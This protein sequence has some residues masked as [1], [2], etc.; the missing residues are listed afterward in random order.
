ME[1]LV[2]Q[3]LRI[4]HII[5]GFTALVVAPL[6]MIAK[7]GGDGHRRWGK[8]FFYAM[9]VVATTA[10]IIGILRP[11]VL[12]ALVAVMSFHMVASG[13][14][15]LYHKRVHEGQRAG[16]WDLILQG[17][18]GAVNGGLFIW[19]FTKLVLGH[20]DNGSILFLVFGLIGS[21]FVWRNMQR[22]YKR[23]H[24]KHEWLFAHMT[25]F[26]GGY[27]ATI[28]A[29]SAVNMGFIKPVWLQW[30]WP[31]IMGAPLIF[32][33]VR[34]YKKKFTRGRRARDVMEVRIK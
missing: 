21:L 27:I 14:R 10:I 29:F 25:G 11:N 9:V 31:T 23:S 34:Y 5:S 7:K 12:L 19:G 13:Y 1:E 26:L 33:W 8:V 4:L 20:R 30:L 24:D 32:I 15:A 22:F 2:I 6:A 28:S 3:G 17:G 18:A 16:R